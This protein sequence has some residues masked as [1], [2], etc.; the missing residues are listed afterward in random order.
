MDRNATEHQIKK[1]Y[2]VLALKFHPDKTKMQADYERF[3]DINEAYHILGK[4]ESREDYN[5][6]YDYRYTGYRAASTDYTTPVGK[7]KSGESRRGF[8]KPNY[9]YRKRQEVDLS[10]YVNSVRIISGLTFIFVFLI[11]LDYFLPNVATNQTIIAKLSTYNSYNSVIIATEKHDFPLSY[12]HSKLIYTG[13]N[14]RVELTP[15]FNIH[16]RLVVDT[17]LDTFIFRPHY[18]IYNVYSFFLVILLGTSCLGTFQ[19][20]DNAELVFSAGVANVFLSIL[21][22]FLIH[23]S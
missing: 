8:Y 1:A 13:D 7:Y 23:I 2:R 5:L 11:V 15:I 10:P 22:I 20:K 16:Q 14:A 9:V 21:I 3:T 17:G 18:S 6:T 12:D 19:N 4:K